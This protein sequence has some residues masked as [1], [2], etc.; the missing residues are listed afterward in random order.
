MCIRD[1]DSNVM[2]M[3]TKA[4]KFCASKTGLSEK[5]IREAVYDGDCSVCEYLRYGL[6]QAMAE[7]SEGPLQGLAAVTRTRIG[8]GEIIL[9]GTLPL[10]ADLSKLILTLAQ[11]RGVKPVAKGKENILLIPREGKYQ[12]LIV[13]ELNNQQ[14]RFQ[15]NQPMTD[16]LT[17]QRYSPGEVIVPP[18]GL[19]VLK[20]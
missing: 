7:Y 3:M 1:R 20:A 6:A 12:G 15:L 18:Y 17:G 4:V 5:R 13:I 9:L 11:E 16:L 8:K 14:G 2:A 10:P 19:L